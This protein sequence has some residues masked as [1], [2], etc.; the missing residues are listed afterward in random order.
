MTLNYTPSKWGKEFHSLT[1]DEALGAGSVGP[2]KSEVLY[3]E[4]LSQIQVEH[5]RFT[6]NFDSI[7]PPGYWLRDLAEKHPLSKDPRTGRGNSVGWALYLRRKSTTLDQAIARV[8]KIIFGIDPSADYNSQ[9]KTFTLS[10][11]YKYQLGS[12]FNL[13]DYLDYYSQEYTMLLWDELVQFDEMQYD[14]VG[15]RLR[16]SDPV[17]VHMLKNRSM[18]NPVTTAVEGAKVKNPLWVRER[19]VD[20]APEGRVT[21]SKK[22]TRQ[23]GRTETLTRIYLP[24]RLHDNPNKMFVEQYERRLLNLPK[25][26]QKAL[27]GGD[28]YVTANSFFAEDWEPSIHICNPFKIPSHWKRF[29]S[30]DWGFKAPGVIHWWA[31]NPEGELFCERELKFRG[32]TAKEVA[33]IVKDIE[34]S[35]G[36]WGRR[37]SLITGPADTQLWEERGDTGVTKAA[38]FLKAGVRWKKATKGRRS[39]AERISK[40]LKS[41]DNFTKHPDICFFSSCKYIIKTLPGMMTDPDDITIPVDGGDDHGY[42]SV[43]YATAFASRGLK[44]IPS[45]REESSN[46]TNKKNRGQHGYG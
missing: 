43:S 40:L 20:E 36:L 26:L 31:M 5:A 41:H 9:K 28:W 27:I 14:E 23:D 25:H 37:R 33:K 13:Y 35:M 38:E 7:G 29:R 2:G 17:L 24:A 12:C 8:R 3:H 11:G 39:A 16:T 4:P 18:S 19:F 45:L 32:K 15:S 44:G 34:T 42:D 46:E 30:M 21:L 6:G 22:V 10:S 1:H